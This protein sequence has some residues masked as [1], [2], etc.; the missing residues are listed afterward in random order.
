MQ[1]R[2]V[3]KKKFSF[4][5]Q[6]KQ[7]VVWLITIIFSTVYIILAH[8]IVANDLNIF[9]ME[10]AYVEKGKVIQI[11]DTLIDEYPLN[12]E[13]TY[14]NSE[15][16][17]YCEL[18]TGK[19]KGT[20]VLAVQTSDNFSEASEEAVSVGD[21][22]ILY[23]YGNTGAEY[24]WI[25][26]GY[27]RAEILFF[28]GIAFFLLL[29]LF[30]QIKGLNTIISLTYTV[31]AIFF[32]FIPSV[33]N[34]YNVYFMSTITCIFIIIMTLLITNGATSKSLATIMG[35]I[36]GVST[37]AILSVI[38][39]KLLRLTGLL[40]E[41]SIYLTYLDSGVGI[42]LK[43]LIYAMIVIGALGAV[44]DVA[45]DIASSLYEIR[46]HVESISFGDLVKSGLRIGR[47]VMGTMANTLV[48]AYIGSSLCSILLLITYAASLRELLNREAIVVEI[49]Q[50]LIG[51]TAILL[52]IPL[53]AIVCGVI[54]TGGK[55]RKI[56]A[57][58]ND[59][60]IDLKPVSTMTEEEK[61]TYYYN[62]DSNL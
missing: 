4:N 54:Y 59:T 23:N 60:N 27:A 9:N 19:N 46:H 56:V 6:F 51:S 11:Q 32:I 30:G 33:L 35:C 34:G 8:S 53:T 3:N 16:Y 2:L 61:Q 5:F 7:F 18:L 14:E 50:A 48:L 29:L 25:F 40:D 37:A 26:G 41:H 36:F 13:I 45:M 44:M 43:A 47:D 42:D 22:V 12:E 1:R 49:L 31:L 21:R 28:F 58:S 38:F 55:R 17:F 20:Q 24:D 52:T 62:Y 57:K 10:G 15:T 39:D